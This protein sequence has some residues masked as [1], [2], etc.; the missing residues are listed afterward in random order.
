MLAG[1]RAGVRAH[2]PDWVLVYGDTNSTLAGRGRRRE[3]AP[4]ASPTSR[5]AC[6]RSTGGCRRSTTGCSPTTPPTCCSRRPRSRWATSPTRGS[7]ARSVLVGDVMTDVLFRRVRGSWP[8]R[9]PAARRRR[10]AAA[11]TSRPST[12][13]TTPTTPTRL[14]GDR[15]GAGGARPHPCCCSRTRGSRRGRRARHRARAG[16]LRAARPAR[17]PAAG[18]RRAGSAGVVT[19][20]GGLQKEAFLLRVPCTTLRPETEWVETVDAR[21]ERARRP[22]WPSLRG[23]V[24]RA[25]ARRRPTRT[26]TAT[27]T[28]PNGW[29]TPSWR[30][31]SGRPVPSRSASRCSRAPRRVP[32]SPAGACG[33]RPAAGP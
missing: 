7:P 27:A 14:R 32:R 12:G 33:S 9:P 25:G 10:A 17:L 19:D 13:P 4:A 29:P 20:S 30:R 6:A 28:R 11:T 16:S 5:P 3:A 24:E 26:R 15:R 21:L 8:S 2:R 31:A 23:A 22:T 1:A 18:R